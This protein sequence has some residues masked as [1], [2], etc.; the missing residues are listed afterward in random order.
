MILYCMSVSLNFHLKMMQTGIA[1][2]IL[3]NVHNVRAKLNVNLL[4]VY[5]C[6]VWRWQHH[7]ETC[8]VYIFIWPNSRQWATA[9]SFLR[10][11]DYTRHT[12][13]G[14]TPLDE[15][16]VRHR[17]LYLTTHNSHNRQTSMSSEEF[18]PTNPASERP[19]THAL[20]REATGT[21]CDVHC[22]VKKTL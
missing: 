7:V 22:N 19:Q 5:V 15:W 3:Q 21:V 1:R 13:V 18:E 10:F 11:L 14:R 17:D 12:T 9:S 2:S 16:S 6:V 4:T 8:G 20:D